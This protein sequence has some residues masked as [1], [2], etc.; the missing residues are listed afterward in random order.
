M[1][2][3]LSLS[4]SS[5]ALSPKEHMQG[6]QARHLDGGPWRRE[7]DDEEEGGT[8][9]FPLAFFSHNDNTEFKRA[10][11]CCVVNENQKVDLI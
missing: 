5:V 1:S 3:Y 11:F 4:L 6:G 10:K 7:D 9:E 8:K 2:F